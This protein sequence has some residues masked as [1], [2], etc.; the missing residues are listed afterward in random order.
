MAGTGSHDYPL[1]IHSDRRPL[2]DLCS[3]CTR[4]DMRVIGAILEYMSWDNNMVSA[5]QRKVQEALRDTLGDEAPSLPSINGSFKFLQ[6]KPR[7]KATD[8]KRET[9]LAYPMLLRVGNGSYMVNPAYFRLGDKSKRKNL[10]ERWASLRNARDRARM[11]I[12]DT[13]ETACGP[14]PQP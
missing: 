9:S 2:I 6:G 11:A 8:A 5:S 13:D 14:L 3:R 4:T 7:S 12:G 1:Y 10:E